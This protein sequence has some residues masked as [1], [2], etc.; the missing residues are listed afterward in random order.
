MWYIGLNT[1]V[2]TV[3]GIHLRQIQKLIVFIKLGQNFTQSFRATLLIKNRISER[4]FDPHVLSWLHYFIKILRIII[5][6]LK[7]SYSANNYLTIKEHTVILKN[8]VLESISIYVV[9]PCED[10]TN[11]SVK[12]TQPKSSVAVFC[13]LAT[14]RTSIAYDNSSQQVSPYHF[15]LLN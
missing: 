2:S 14:I 1:I 6:Q 11:S 7:S 3:F 5:W 4:I 13:P 8:C 9:L 10:K 15:W 12:T